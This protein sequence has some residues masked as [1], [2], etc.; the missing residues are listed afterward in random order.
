MGHRRFSYLLVAFAVVLLGASASYAQDPAGRFAAHPKQAASSARS[1]AELD[2]PGTQHWVDSG[3]DVQ[4]GDRFLISVS[5]KLHYDASNEN[6]PEGLPRGWRDLIRNMPVNSLGRGAAIARIGDAESAQPFLVGAS[7]EIR[8]TSSGRLFLGINQPGN[9][10]AEGS[11]HVKIEILERAPSSKP[12]APT[13]P[14]A[15]PPGAAS[16]PAPAVPLQSQAPITAPASGATLPQEATPAQPPAFPTDLLKQIPRRIADKDGNPGD[17]VNF[18]MIGSEEQVRQ[19]FQSA[20]WVQVDRSTSEAVLHGLLA[21]L[22]KE[23]YVQMP[24]SELYLFG[25]PQDF[26][27]AHA[28]PIAVVASRHHLRLWKSSLTVDGQPLWVGAATHDIGFERDQRNG[29]V[30]HKI[31]PA[32]DD[33]RTYVEQ[34]LSQ[35]G[36]FSSVTYARPADALTEAKTATGGSFH[37]DGRILVL[38]L[39]PS[40]K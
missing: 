22:S 17:M 33:E 23:A 24:M 2:V 9:E 34:T 19:A 6:G 14:V 25:R 4:P 12:Q 30:T 16:A 3:I 36:L 5:G 7:K 39:A 8:S 18:M 40:T 31:E 11:Y 10:Q 32:V 20:G 13:A 1:S 28:E 26:G 29:K 35:T 38:V 15:T 27:F 21:S 37:S